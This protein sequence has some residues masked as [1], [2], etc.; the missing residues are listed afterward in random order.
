MKITEYCYNLL[1]G[2]CILC[3]IGFT[4]SA[5]LGNYFAALPAILFFVIL[6][7]TL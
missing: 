4:I 1:V 5:I 7:L 6:K 2:M 3:F